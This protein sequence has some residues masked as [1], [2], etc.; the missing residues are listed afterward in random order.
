[1][2]TVR[3]FLLF[4]LFILLSGCN[5]IHNEDTKYDVSVVDEH[6]L[7]AERINESYFKNDLVCIKTHI[8]N[9]S[10]IDI[11]VNGNN[12]GKYSRCD[13]SYLYY[14]FNMPSTDV[15]IDIKITKKS[16]ET[17]YL[18]DYINFLDELDINRIVEVQYIEYDKSN[19]NQLLD[20]LF[21]NDFNDVVRIFNYF[22][23]LLIEEVKNITADMDNL[24]ESKC[25]YCFI[26]E[27]QVYKIELN[28]IIEDNNKFYLVNYDVPKM[29][30][31]EE[32]KT[33]NVSNDYYDIHFLTA[34]PHIIEQNNYLNNIMFVE[35][36]NLDEYYLSDELYVDYEN[37]KIRIIDSS[38]FEYKGKYYQIIGSL[39]F[40]NAYKHTT[41][42]S[43]RKLSYKICVI[44][45]N[46]S[47]VIFNVKYLAG[48]NMTIEDI[49]FI[50]TQDYE[51]SEN[52]EVYIDSDCTI[53]L[54]EM[55]VSNNMNLY[56]K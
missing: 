33:F 14:Y 54:C 41:I 27:E 3:I 24:S 49:W 10:N 46:S 32:A 35:Y 39:N 42:I 6:N 8:L 51:F 5:Y 11:F 45:S 15:I 43:S 4:C 16:D 56:V 47:N 30:K 29:E 21:S 34:K 28:H 25:S 38:H 50:L 52:N 12:I 17:K 2:K 20:V 40:Y 9:D 36:D 7:L 22:K 48:Q 13:D 37:T 53:L 23:N 44:D 26:T 19:D 31:S 55:I 1:M 18:S